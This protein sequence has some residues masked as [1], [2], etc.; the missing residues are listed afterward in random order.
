VLREG[1][2]REQMFAQYAKIQ[3]TAE[4]F[5]VAERGLVEFDDDAE[6]FRH[7]ATFPK[8]GPDAGT[9]HALLHKDQGVEYVYFCDP[10]PRIRV[11]ADPEALKNPA[12]YEAYTCLLLKSRPKVEA[13][14]RSFDD[15]SS[16]RQDAASTEPDKN[17]RPPEPDR[18]VRPPELDR[19]A[20]GALR[21]GWKAGGEA[22]D[23]IGA[24][25]LIRAGKMRAEESPFSLRD[26]RTGKPVL[27][28][29][30]SVAWNDY[31]RRWI[32]IFCEFGGV[33]MLGEIWYAEAENLL[34]PWS[35]ARKIV[36]HDRYSFYNPKHHP[37]FDRQGGRIIYFEGTY[38]A[39]FSNNTDLTPR[40]D[41]NQ[42]MYKLDLADPRLHHATDEEP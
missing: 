31:R 4:D 22:I 40:Y 24:D 11:R 23:P 27:A 25:K 16:K 33:S 3:G 1:S 14:S 17:V 9:G 15:S 10:F 35:A 5:K 30:G 2:D 36:T 20:D 18:N 34:G 6:I 13:A 21:W 41:Y 12:A 19:G 7:V 42:I 8:S 29:R 39:A 28:H 38:T 37:C 26:A 32:M